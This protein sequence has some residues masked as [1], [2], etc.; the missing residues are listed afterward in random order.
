MYYNSYLI[1]HG[2]KGMKWGVR[3]KEESS[4]SSNTNHTKKISK[5]ERLSEYKSDKGPKS[6]AFTNASNSAAR[7]FFKAERT[8]SFNTFRK[9][10]SERTLKEASLTESQIKNGRYRVARA[11]SIKRTVLTT[12]G[13]LGLG[14]LAG[15][16][17]GGAALLVTPAVAT[18]AAI[19][20]NFITGAHYYGKQR[21]AYGS[22]RAK[23]QTQSQVK[24]RGNY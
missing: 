21:K 23:Y 3:K 8:K 24:N 11:R 13:S 16:A 5:K 6:N 10:N 1:H 7:S 12:W 4:G 9:A 17:S 15:A 19:P 20:L 14:T 22:T 2:V 18:A